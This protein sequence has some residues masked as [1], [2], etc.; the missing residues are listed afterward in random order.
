MRHGDIW[1]GIDALA[2]QNG[3]ST[4]GLAKLAGLDATA[5]NKSK[6]L[7][8]DGRPRWPTTESVARIIDAVN[9]DFT[10]FAALVANASEARL[11][12]VR[13]GRFSIDEAGALSVEQDKKSA[14]SKF[15]FEPGAFVIE[16][17]GESLAPVFADGD[18]LLVLPEA[19]CRTGD[20]ALIKTRMGQELI[21]TCRDAKAGGSA[22]FVNMLDET[23]VFE[24]VDLAWAAKV[25]LVG[26]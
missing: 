21:A 13:Q 20:H 22:E 12:L 4:S 3:L 25:V 2:A 6:R 15:N 11:P 16:I 7:A 19:E 10:E 18:R 9:S 1:R 14:P 17:E 5:F 8:K 26:P 23:S 24:R